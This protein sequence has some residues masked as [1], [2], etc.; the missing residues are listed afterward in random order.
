VSAPADRPR[1][2][3]TINV[4][5]WLL[6]FLWSL[7]L[8][9]EL[10]HNP[11]GNI[12]RI[13]RFLG[14]QEGHL[15]L[16]TALGLFGHYGIG[17]FGPTFMLP[18]GWD[19]PMNNPVWQPIAAIALLALT[20]AGTWLA[21]RRRQTFTAAVGSLSLLGSLLGIVLVYGI[22]TKVSDHQ[23]FWVSLFILL[24][25]AAAASAAADAWLRTGAMTARGT[26]GVA[27]VL[28]IALFA[29]TMSQI[30]PWQDG[31]SQDRPL[32]EMYGKFHDYLLSIHSRAPEIRHTGATWHLAVGLVLQFA[33]HQQSV[34][35]D[36]DLVNIAGERYRV[37]DTTTESYLLFDANQDVKI[38]VRPDARML[39]RVG[40]LTL[41]N[42]QDVERP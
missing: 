7:P 39:I 3:S 25:V 14:E 30:R 8:A 18:L 34:R 38:K 10:V 29:V 35:I 23:V 4:T 40:S 1:L 16:G 13:L 37:K 2:R 22:P 26:R 31:V 11:A 19:A 20:A 17:P 5:A 12:D 21:F 33:K 41:V 6:L 15:A 32:T 42:L 9:E 36:D 27:V 28:G 24:G